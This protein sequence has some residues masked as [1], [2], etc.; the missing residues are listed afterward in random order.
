MGGAIAILFV[1]PWLD[2]SPVKSMLYKGWISRIFLVAF[3]FSFVTLGVLGVLP[4][5]DSRTLI[6]QIASL[7]YLAFFTFMP[8][9]TRWENTKPVPERM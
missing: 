7:V 6:A 4:S 8:W 5:T 1:L 3:C 9:Y 2:R